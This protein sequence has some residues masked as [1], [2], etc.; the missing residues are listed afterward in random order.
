MIRKTGP[1]ANRPRHPRPGADLQQ[2]ADAAREGAL[3]LP[4][5]VAFDGAMPT[6][7][8]FAESLTA[9]LRAELEEF[10][11][12]FQ[13]TLPTS[14]DTQWHALEEHDVGSYR[15]AYARRP[16]SPDLGTVWN[17]RKA[18]YLPGRQGT[19]TAGQSIRIFASKATLAALVIMSRGK[20]RALGLEPLAAASIQNARDTTREM[21]AM[22][23]KET[24]DVNKEDFATISLLPLLQRAAKL[25][26]RSRGGSQDTSPCR[27]TRACFCR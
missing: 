7:F 23:A 4:F 22:M 17:K 5:V 19:R 12:T 3:G 18:A 1:E 2:P 27:H 14:N 13:A 20:A 8:E 15:A 25:G 16:Y 10:V 21:R 6:K 11:R 24:D 26:A 9:G